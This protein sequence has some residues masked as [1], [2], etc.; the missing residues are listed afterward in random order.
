MF[1]CLFFKDIRHKLPTRVLLL[2]L[3]LRSDH[4]RHFYKNPLNSSQN[5][6]PAYSLYILHLNIIVPIFKSSQITLCTTTTT[7]RHLQNMEISMKR[8][9]VVFSYLVLKEL[10]FIMISSHKIFKLF[11]FVIK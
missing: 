2:I 11:V 3:S 1:G 8:L 7:L 4:L 10:L 6:V 5:T 9:N